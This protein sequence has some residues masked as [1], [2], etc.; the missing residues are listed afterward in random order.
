MKYI[1]THAHITSDFYKEDEL[2]QLMENTST[3]N[4]ESFFVPGTNI[5]SSL[6]AIELSKRFDNVYAGVGIHPSDAGKDDPSFLDGI[7]YKNVLFIGETGL[8]LHYD[9][10]P[11]IEVQI[12]SFKKHIEIAIKHNLPI[13]VHV[14]D[15]YDEAYEVMKQYENVK[16][17]LHSFSGSIEWANKFLDLGAHISF[18]GIVTFKNAKEMQ[19]VA[20]VIPLD[21]I[22]CETDSPFLTPSPNR[23][24]K[25][26]PSNVKHVVDFI[27]SLRKEDNVEQAI[28]SNTKRLFNI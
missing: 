1:D 17:V 14:R 26:E 22:I 9:D 2:K 11:P 18:S 13:E 27:A 21:R 19:E 20:K 15:A 12:E 4:V 25:N 5:K 23:G 3:N 24:K 7:D 6:E 10:N 16:Y 8:D 28:Y